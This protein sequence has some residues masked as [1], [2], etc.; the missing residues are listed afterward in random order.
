MNI[1]EIINK[2]S[3]NLDL[4]NQDVLEILE[5]DKLRIEIVKYLIEEPNRGF[6]LK[7]LEKV[8][9]KRKNGNYELGDNENIM[10]SCYLVGLHNNIEDSLLIWNTK[11]VDYDTFCGL[12][13]QLVV[14]GGVDN[15]LE[16]LKTINSMESE[17]AS[18]Y[19]NTCNK[20]GDFDELDV[21]FSKSELPYWV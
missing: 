12:D 17:K 2:Y 20:A 10:F 15:T 18:D 6:S 4:S 7:I 9:E 1:S 8:V 3:S 21:Y 14:F 11:N 5:N 13:V 16:Y 19:L